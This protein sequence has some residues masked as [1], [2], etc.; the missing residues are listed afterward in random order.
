MLKQLVKDYIDLLLWFTSLYV[1]STLIICFLK[2]VEL[3]FH[4][5]VSRKCLGISAFSH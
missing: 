1:E 4:F 3:L 5:R 2:A